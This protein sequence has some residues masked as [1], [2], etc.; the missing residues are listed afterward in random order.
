MNWSSDE[1]TL[2][3][4]DYLRMLTLEL[5]GQSFS[6]A[7]HRRRLQQ[8]LGSR[9]EASIEFKHQNI[10]AVLIE[11]GYPFIRGYQPRTHYQTSLASEVVAQVQRLPLLDD[12]ALAAVDKPAV[13][14]LQDDFSTVRAE[15]PAATAKASEPTGPFAFH[16]VKRDYLAREAHNRSLGLAGESFVVGFERWRLVQLGAERLAHKVEHVSQSWGDLS[17]IHI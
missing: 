2:V 7:A 17:L 14:P 12:A 3:V 11:L 15:A 5:S 16:A 10:S 9:T 1:V 6:K 8:Q 4:A 13:T